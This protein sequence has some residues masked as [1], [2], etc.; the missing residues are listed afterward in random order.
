M[1][2]HQNAQSLKDP[3]N[4]NSPRTGYF[5][6]IIFRTNVHRLFANNQFQH[7]PSIDRLQLYGVECD[8]DPLVG[9]AVEHVQTS[10][11][12]WVVLGETRREELTGFDVF[13][14]MEVVRTTRAPS[15]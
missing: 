7:Q 9:G 4:N 2:P 8:E 5:L 10:R 15:S 14:A 13:I 6:N 1:T 3:R 12:G 11:V